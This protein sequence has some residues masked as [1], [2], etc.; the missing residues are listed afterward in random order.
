MH[1]ITEN[2]IMGLLSVKTICGILATNNSSQMIW[3]DI[4]FNNHYIIYLNFIFKMIM[5]TFENNNDVKTNVFNF[6]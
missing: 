3:F 5:D 1:F 4:L 6:C 2:I